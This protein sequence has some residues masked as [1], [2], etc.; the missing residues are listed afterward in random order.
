MGLHDLHQAW[1]DRFT[2]V[3]VPECQAPQPITLAPDM[4]PLPPSI[5]AYCAY[6]FTAENLAEALSA[7]LSADQL[8]A[9]REEQMAFLQQYKERKEHERQAYL[10]KVAPGWA[11]GDHSVLQ[12][13]PA[14]ALHTN[15]SHETTEPCPEAD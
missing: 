6:P 14:P 5:D 9:Q 10:H 7:R 8:R 11:H 4:H 3:Q 1:L 15:D 12:P 13:T 2:L